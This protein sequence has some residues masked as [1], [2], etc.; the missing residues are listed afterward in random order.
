[1]NYPLRAALRAPALLFFILTAWFGLLSYIPFAYLQFLRHQ[2][3]SWIEF[4]VI[5]HHFLYWS[6]FLLAL[7]SIAT[8]LADRRPT[9]WGFAVTFAVLGVWLARHPVLPTLANNPWSLT[10]AGLAL[11]PPLWLALID[12]G[13]VRAALDRGA[14]QRRSH[15][16]LTTL[17]QA[18][19][20]AAVCVWMTFVA[21]AGIQVVRDANSPVAVADLGIGVVWSLVANLVLGTFVCVVLSVARLLARSWRAE[22]LLLLTAVAAAGWVI[23]VQI[24]F[25]S[26]AFRGTLA[27]AA[28]ATLGLSG[29]VIWSGLAI[30][31]RRTSSEPGPALQTLLAPIALKRLPATIAMGGVAALAYLAVA[32][33]API[34][35]AFLLQKLIAVAVWLMMFSLVYRFAARLPYRFAMFMMAAS[36]AGFAGRALARESTVMLAIDRY[37]PLD[38]SLLL[39][40][41]V[42]KPTSTELAEIMSFLVENS[43]LTNSRGARAASV[44]FVKPLT[45]SAHRTPHI[46]IF[47]M[48]S[49]RR[50]YLSPYN[51]SVTFTPAL[52]AFARESLV[53]KNAFTQYGGTGLSEPA[54]WSGALL[55][56]KQYVV[57]FAPMNALEKLLDTQ[58][59]KRL[60]SV[61]SILRELLSSSPSMHELDAGV[62][63]RL[64][65]SCRTLSEIK[66]VV[67]ATASGVPIFAFSQPQDVHLANVSVDHTDVAK[68]LYRGFHPQYAA[69]VRRFD[70]CFGSFIEF[71][72]SSGIYE[73]SILVL[74]S[75]HGDS[76]GDDGRWGHSFTV[77]PE[78]IRVPL[79]IHVPDQLRHGSI[80]D[81]DAVAFNTDITPTLYKLMGYSPAEHHPVL[82]SSLLAD[83]HAA[84][85]SRRERPHLVISSYGP[86]YGLLRNNGTSLY[87]VDGVNTAE[88]QYDLS[89]GLNGKRT[90]ITDQ[91]R[92]T[93]WPVIRSHVQ[94]IADFYGY[95][96]ER[97]VD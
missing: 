43:D 89:H 34:D 4:F 82:G 24:V 59:Y 91:E 41:Q 93:A 27:H 69:R 15:T 2:L 74:T 75:D 12:H 39:I 35:W 80:V 8:D 48:D 46:F 97:S 42:V 33:I 66:E 60:I 95:S 32:R 88:Y 18:S 96:T 62:Q 29:A 10:V 28:A 19:F 49:L 6:A 44:D 57:P 17:V 71:L 54:I 37:K 26:I 63:N 79:M 76:L 61:D 21:I 94:A 58:G 40:D 65:D 45:P 13:G 7:L 20:G 23:L 30:R 14:G 22:F 50:D 5:F 92:S 77:F 67:S 11:V 47:V 38:A 25:P 53:F 56:H 72:K 9:A 3:F 73:N 85:R 1:M 31:A 70:G 86:V 55:P 68:D 81:P 64:Y 87:I 78:V 84:L 52:G 83:S 90:V 36:I 16:E 51:P